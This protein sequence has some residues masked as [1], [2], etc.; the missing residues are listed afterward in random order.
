MGFCVLAWFSTN[1]VF[2]NDLVRLLEFAMVL[3]VYDRKFL[4]QESRANR[5]PAATDH[6]GSFIEPVTS[7]FAEGM[8]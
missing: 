7:G 5:M 8:F 2:S 3:Y 4:R 6:V 1:F